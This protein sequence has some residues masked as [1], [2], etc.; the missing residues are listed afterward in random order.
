MSAG[1]SRSISAAE[2][3]AALL[4]ALSR[5]VRISLLR[6]AMWGMVSELHSTLD[7]DYVAYADEHLA[8]FETR[9]RLELP[10][11]G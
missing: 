3:D 7:I 9:G 1:C 6:E 4:A 10:E 11:A 8:K 5:D 2:A